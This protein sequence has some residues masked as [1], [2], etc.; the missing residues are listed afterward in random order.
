MPCTRAARG[1]RSRM[2][3]LGT[4]PIFLRRSALRTRLTK[5]QLIGSAPRVTMPDRKCIVCGNP[6]PKNRG[7]RAK[8]C[9]RECSENKPDSAPPLLKETRQY[10]YA[11]TPYQR[12]L[13]RL[14]W[15]QLHAARVLGIDPR[16]SR[17]YAS[18][19][20]NTPEAV[21]RKLKRKTK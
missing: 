13:T 20:L 8:T 4:T 1:T 16:T 14:G 2:R 21:I 11:T 12:H 5:R 19:D 10:E 6:I 3:I 17:R 7:L 15:S 9:S 18:G